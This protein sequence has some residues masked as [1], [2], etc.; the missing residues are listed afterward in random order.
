MLLFS[1][2]WWRRHVCALNHELTHSF[3]FIHY[4][5]CQFNVWHPASVREAW[6]SF[7][8]QHLM[9]F[10]DVMVEK[11][12]QQRRDAA[13]LQPQEWLTEACEVLHSCQVFPPLF[14]VSVPSQEDVTVW[15]WGGIDPET[16]YLM[17][18]LLF[19]AEQK[20]NQWNTYVGVHKL[21]NHRT[22]LWLRMRCA[23]STSLKPVVSLCTTSFRPPCCE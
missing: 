17:P 14:T 22:S 7:V 23:F 1:S 6:I 16:H 11:H 5:V 12:K 19:T 10:Y 13:C 15:Q 18:A 21:S 20:T 4:S 9:V 2:S 3:R 8:S